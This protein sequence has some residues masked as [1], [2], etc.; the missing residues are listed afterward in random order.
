MDAPITSLPNNDMPLIKKTGGL[1]NKMPPVKKVSKQKPAE[2]SAAEEKME[3]PAFEKI[4]DAHDETTQIKK[5]SARHNA[6]SKIWAT[7]SKSAGKVVA[8]VKK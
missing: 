3:S 7:P 4:E 6:L 1:G 8:K 5:G 2:G